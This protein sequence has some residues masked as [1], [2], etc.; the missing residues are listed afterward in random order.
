MKK[1]II[2]TH[3]LIWTL[4]DPEKLSKNIL[5]A[6]AE[7]GEVQ[8]SNINFWEISIKYRLGKLDLGGLSP[9]DIYLAAKESNFKIIDIDSQTTSTLYQLPLKDHKDPFDRLLIWHSIRSKTT[10]IS[11][12]NKFSQYE[13]D[14]LIL[15]G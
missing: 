8:V 6:Y 13:E 9:E 1:Y 2:D 4:L 7:V 5:Q 14:G 10:L 12:D 15:L 11:R 3:I